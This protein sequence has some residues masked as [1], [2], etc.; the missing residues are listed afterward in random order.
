L[1]II[2]VVYWLALATASLLPSGKNVLGGWD[3]DIDPTW[4]N[5]LHLPAYAGLTVLVS[6]S[7]A[8]K[9]SV[10]AR[11]ILGIVLSCCIFG[12]L[13]ECAQVFIP[14]RSAG[15]D[16]ALIN[17]AGAAVGC[18]VAIWLCRRPQVRVSAGIEV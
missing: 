16:D 12:A 3:Q 2:T 18:P 9:R 4:Q 8:V 15:V 17:V 6:L 11:S 5:W 7:V 14:G 1:R 10:G 13:M